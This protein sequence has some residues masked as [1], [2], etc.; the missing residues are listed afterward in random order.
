[1]LYFTNPSW[2][3]AR[4]C[5]NCLEDVKCGQSCKETGLSTPWLL[6]CTKDP[7]GVTGPR[8]PSRMV[9]ARKWRLWEPVTVEVSFCAHGAA[10]GEQHCLLLWCAPFHQVFGSA[11]NTLFQEMCQ[12]RANIL[13]I[14][15]P[16]YGLPYYCLESIRVG[17]YVRLWP[18]LPAESTQI[19]WFSIDL[20]VYS[21][22]GR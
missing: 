10:G 13:G 6:G 20:P 22:L 16:S 19:L 7:A 14:Y 9:T 12:E 21:F 11:C 5:R 2:D 4:G 3:P 15:R 1:M 8:D 18:F 17:I